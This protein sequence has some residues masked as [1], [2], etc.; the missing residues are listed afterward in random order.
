MASVVINATPE[1]TVPNGAKVPPFGT[2]KGTLIKALELRATYRL[3]GTLF[4]IGQ[5]ARKDALGLLDDAKC[6]YL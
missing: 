4:M 5:G 6:M 1:V 2:S 3:C